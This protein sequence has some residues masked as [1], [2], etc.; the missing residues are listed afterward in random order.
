MQRLSGLCILSMTPACQSMTGGK[1][2]KKARFKLTSPS[3]HSL[4]KKKMHDSNSFLQAILLLRSTGG[5]T[6]VV[7]NKERWLILSSVKKWEALWS[8]CHEHRTKKKTE[9]PRGI[10]PETFRTPLRYS[11]HWTTMDSWRAGHI[12]INH[13]NLYMAQLATSPL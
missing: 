5:M 9:S 12:H 10:E 13:T 1:T 8:T 2:D 7:I 3:P 4:W 11:N 6:I